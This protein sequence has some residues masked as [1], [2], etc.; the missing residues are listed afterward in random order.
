MKLFLTGILLTIQTIFSQGN[1]IKL[2][3]PETGIY[4]TAFST[5][6]SSSNNVSEKEVPYFENLAGKKIV[7]LNFSNDWFNGIKFPLES[8]KNI[9][10]SGA[11]PSIR[12][13]PWKSYDKNDR[14]YPL[15]KIVNGGFDDEL[16]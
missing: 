15:K 9:W 13:M 14:A 12:I 4:H 10:K 8:V 7:W 3:P 6:Y 1:E 16:K 11:L 2:L 5:I